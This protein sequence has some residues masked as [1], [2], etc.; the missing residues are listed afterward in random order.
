MILRHGASKGVEGRRTVPSGRTFATLRECYESIQL[1]IVRRQWLGQPRSLRRLRPRDLLVLQRQPHF[2]SCEFDRG[3]WFGR[4]QRL[5]W[6]GHSRLHMLGRQR[7]LR[8]LRRNR[9]GPVLRAWLA[10]VSQHRCC[11]HTLVVASERLGR[12]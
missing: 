7:P 9:K 2:L 3:E 4:L 11:G 6:F 10:M 12:R 8:V 1:F 5:W